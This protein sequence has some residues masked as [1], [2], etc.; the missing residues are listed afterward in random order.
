MRE[1][2][3]CRRES[4]TGSPR[5]LMYWGKIL[6]LLLLVTAS[7]ARAQETIV[8]SE[9]FE[10]NDG[11]F[12]L[13]YGTTAG[14]EWGS[15]TGSVGPGKA[16]GGSKCWGTVLN[17]ALPRPS[18]GSIISPPIALPT[19]ASNQVLRVRFWAFVSIDGMYDR[20]EFLVSKDG[21]SWQS[22]M[23]MYQAM[24]SSTNAAPGWRSYE[25]TLD[26]SY[27]GG[28]V[29]LRFRAAVKS[30]SPTFYCGGATD[31]SG[32]YV[33]DIA[34]TL[35]QTSGTQKIFGM[36]AW[37]DASAW[38][39]CPWVAPWNGT[40][41]ET[42][43]DIY[44][45]ARNPQGEYTDYYRLNKPLVARDGQYPVEILEED[46]E[47]SYTDYASLLQVDHAPDVA[48]APNEK[49]QLVAYR[50]AA[51]QAPKSA[52]TADG[53]DV[54][55]LVASQNDAGYPAYS[56]DTVRLDFANLDLSQGAVLML[57]VKGFVL[58]SGAERPY[59]TAPA[60]V[61]ETL[62]ANQQWQER[63]RLLPRF[64]YTVQAFDLSPYLSNASTQVR[65][66]SISHSVKYHEIDY[67]A[68]QT[69][70]Q[71]S[72][73]VTQTAPSAATFGSTDVLAKLLAPDGDYVK[74][75]TGERFTLSFPAAPLAAGQ[76]REFVLVSKGYYVPKSGS[77]LLYTWD[78]RSWVLRDSFTYPGSATM[79]T[80]DLSLF[81]PDPDGELKVRVWQDY[82]YE[83]AGIDYVTMTAGDTNAPL[84]WAWDFRTAK[85]NFD[86]VKSD[87]GV[88]DSWSG[89]PRNR[90]TQY[91]FEPLLANFPPTV[92]TPRVTPEP[93]YVFSWAYSDRDG[94]PESAFEIQV[95]AGPNATGKI[96]WN[97]GI[98]TG[99]NTTVTYAGPDFTGVAYA[100]MRVFDG[101]D[102]GPWSE[103]AIGAGSTPTVPTVQASA[104]ETNTL[105]VLQTG[106]FYQTVAVTNIDVANID[107]FRLW[108]DGLAP[109]I[110]LY[111]ATG[112]S[113]GVP[114][115]VY[116]STLTPGQ[117]VELALEYY[118]TNWAA[119]PNPTFRI[120]VLAATPPTS[121]VGTTLAV[122]RFLP[123]T[124]QTFLVEFLTTTNTLYYIQYSS[125]LQTWKTALPA[126][127]GNGS[128]IQWLDSGPPKTDSPPGLTNRFYRILRQN[129]TAANA[130]RKSN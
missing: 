36:K 46:T 8:Y 90:V 26:P 42:D 118:V 20:A 4:R 79:K 126:L 25:I 97:P 117:G 82:Q 85:S 103:V 41:F 17:G 123:W 84:V 121:P 19:I 21:S 53:T 27:G 1:L 34:I 105:R 83:G 39:S 113:N 60:V 5:G 64:Q 7:G 32:F 22:L 94:D 115:L 111:N 106:L 101:K 93:P 86:Q 87:D 129:P 69:G 31:L 58:G 37:E 51:L 110:Q 38:A 80:F 102:W 29:Y 76:A 15:P 23:Q 81:L 92:V 30:T 18:E 48:V 73:T 65:L 88:L 89:C 119:V 104:V 128:R 74:M 33:D 130:L 77:Y 100:R 45:V 122:D 72:F 120:E 62:D 6:S 91:Q 63:G 10:E 112:A 66:R 127:Q 57:R 11:G 109:G 14:W 98:F 3:D 67:V 95:W 59:T 108:L 70:Q 55:G 54:L 99:T 52:V 24:D 78:G 114:Y 40:A 9:G 49:G 16:N 61:V 56:G 13:Q 44:S 71:P 96:I 124:N 35:Y 43:N 12:T 125:D 75:S 116:D 68:L 47:D 28:N 50:P 107:A 2:R